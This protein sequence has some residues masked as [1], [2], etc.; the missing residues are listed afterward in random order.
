MKRTTATLTYTNGSFTNEN[1]ESVA[2]G[3]SI[4]Y[5]PKIKFIEGRKYK[6]KFSKNDP[7]KGNSC[8]VFFDG[9]GFDFEKTYRGSLGNWTPLLLGLKGLIP[10][11]LK[12]GAN[13]IKPTEF[14]IRAEEA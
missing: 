6:L 7:R 9:G 11:E 5:F 13:T 8:K 2:C 4:K 10:N 1:G 14:W 3:S 12:E